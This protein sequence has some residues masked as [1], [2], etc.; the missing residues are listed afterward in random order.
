VDF[1]ISG[2]GCGVF[3]LAYHLTQSMEVA[4]RRELEQPLLRAY[5]QTLVEYGVPDYSF[6]QCWYDYRETA[7]IGILYAATVCGSLDLTNERTRALGLLFLDRAL[8]AI[9][10]LRCEETLPR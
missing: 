10:D 2:R 8:S 5:H 7:T 3:D 6:E 1:Q 9:Q 4:A